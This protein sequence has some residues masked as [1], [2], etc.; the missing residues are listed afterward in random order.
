MI[1][2]LV[3]ERGRG[4][5]ITCTGAWRWLG[6]QDS[7]NCFGMHRNSLQGCAA[8]RNRITSGGRI[9]RQ[10]MQLLGMAKT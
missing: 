3:S 2:Q 5:G 9:R 7:G 4:R 1:Q 10:H 6:L 8:G